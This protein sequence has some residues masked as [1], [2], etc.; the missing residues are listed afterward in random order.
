ML[1]FNELKYE[2]IDYEDTKDKIESLIVKLPECL[3]YPEYLSTVKEINAIQNHIEE[4]ADYAD[5]CNMRDIDD[6]YW[7]EEITYWN[8]NKNKFDALF[9]SFYQEILSSKFK[10]QLKEDLPDNFFRVITS[11]LKTVS[12]RNDELIKKENELKRQYRVLNKKEIIFEGK[13]TTIGAV[14]G[15]FSS[16]DRNLRKKAHDTVNDFYYANKDEYQSILFE[17]INVRNAIAKNAGFQSYVDYSL[18]KLKRFGYDYNDIH[19]F[20]NSIVKYIVP[21]CQK[22][23]KWQQEELNLDELFYYDTVFFTEMPELRVKGA[24]L[25]SEL[26][27]SFQTVD[28][29]L[30]KLYTE[31]LDN[32]YIDFLPRASKV[33]FS[34]TNYLTETAMPV[35]TGNYKNTYHDVGSTTHEIGHAFQK[36]CASL[37]DRNHIVSP[38]LKYPTMEI[39]EMFSHAMELIMSDKVE[40]L[41]ASDDYQKYSFMNIYNFVSLLPYICAVDEFQEL[42]YSK[43]DLKV[44]DINDTWLKVA[45]KYHLDK[46]NKGHI[47]LDNGGYYYRQSHIF[48]DPFY[49]IDYALSYVGAILIWHNSKENLAFFKEVGSVASYYSYKDLITKYNMPSPFNEEVIV[50]MAKELDS[51]LMKRRI[52]K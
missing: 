26:K 21:L 13:P 3:D 22:M 30:Y 2:R 36:Y 24:E 5:I 37:E 43:E 19:E 41:F 4:M 31:M 6:A 27:D 50:S 9:L 47:N 44:T 28:T 48:L 49:Y 14:S 42:I 12:S 23:S 18:Y 51:E 10:N 20:R 33:N 15:L 17:A 7:Q 52:L 11:Q 16:K 35:I 29:D 40:G 38:L 34:I 1:K 39:A 25:L 8:T 32:G 46:N 45:K